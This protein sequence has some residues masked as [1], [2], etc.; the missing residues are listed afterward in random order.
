MNPETRELIL[1]V[2][3][4]LGYKP[5]LIARSLSSNKNFRLGMLVEDYDLV[6]MLNPLF[7]RY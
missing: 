6:G 5:N 7:L 3:D 4:E 1:K 2:A